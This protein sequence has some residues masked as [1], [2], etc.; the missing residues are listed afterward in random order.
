M[1]IALRILTTLDV[2]NAAITDS[3]RQF[4]IRIGINQHPDIIVTDIND[5]KNIAGAG[6]NNASRIMGKA[7]G[8]QI[9]VSR[10]VFDDL[11]PSEKYKDSFQPYTATAKH[12]LLLQLYQFIG[13]G[14]SGLNTDVPSAWKKHLTL[15]VAYY[16]AH[17]IQ[18]REFLIKNQSDEKT[19]IAIVLLWLFAVDSCGERGSTEANPH[20]PLKHRDILDRALHLRTSF[21]QQFAHYMRT[22]RPVAGALIPLVQFIMEILEPY[23]S[24]FEIGKF[25]PNLIFVNEAGAGKLKAEWPNIWME[26]NFAQ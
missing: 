5:R 22:Y 26:F 19:V 12:N 11:Q 6:I 25:P 15:V 2:Y 18:N 3:V 16:F 23:Q 7:D 21:T 8:N 4:Q 13:K 17:A 24:Y 1:Q 10:A 14:H 20:V 9:L